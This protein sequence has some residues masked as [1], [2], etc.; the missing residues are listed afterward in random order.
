MPAMPLRPGTIV[1]RSP[2]GR[3]TLPVGSSRTVM[4]CHGLR[5]VP[6]AFAGAPAC[7]LPVAA[8]V[9]RHLDAARPAGR[10]GGIGMCVAVLLSRG[11]QNLLP[12]RSRPLHSR[13][14]NFVAPLGSDT[15]KLENWS[16]FPSDSATF[17]FALSTPVWRASRSLGAACFVWSM[18][19]VSL[20]RVYAGWHYAS[21]ILS[22]ALLGIFTVELVA[23]MLPL[24]SKIMPSVNLAEKH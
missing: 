11:M 5:D 10:G 21:D 14:P 7:H 15:S 22:G 18:L 16:S 6:A 20:P 2:E 1:R 19:V 12:A 4:H 13:N 17:A 9:R 8:I 23:S 3:T 24:D